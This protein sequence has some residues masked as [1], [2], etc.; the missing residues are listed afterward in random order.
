MDI[1]YC[2]SDSKSWDQ[3]AVAWHNLLDPWEHTANI[4]RE[5]QARGAPLDLFSC[6]FGTFQTFGNRVSGFCSRTTFQKGL[7]GYLRPYHDI[8]VFDHYCCL[9]VGSV[10]QVLLV[11]WWICPVGNSSPH[12]L[13]CKNFCY[14]FT[15]FFFSH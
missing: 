15:F 4:W 10:L 2:V 12:A 9:V 7:A 11:F 1:F 6:S 3:M 5:E 14:C 13:S 8:S